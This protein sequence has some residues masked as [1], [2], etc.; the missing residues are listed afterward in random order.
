M[1]MMELK[2]KRNVQYQ[3]TICSV[4]AIIFNKI[5]MDILMQML[6][7]LG[8]KFTGDGNVKKHLQSWRGPEFSSQNLPQVTPVQRDPAFADTIDA[9]N[10][11]ISSFTNT[12]MYEF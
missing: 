8:N 4:R 5:S 11:Y 12:H 2:R 6:E 7:T 1:G 3:L 9:C 10:T